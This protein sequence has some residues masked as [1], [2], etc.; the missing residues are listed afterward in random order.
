MWLAMVLMT[1]YLLSIVGANI[2]SVHWP[3]VLLAGLTIPAGTVFAGVCLTARDLVQDALGWRG[4]TV[5]IAAG[6]GLSALLA[7]PQISV[8]SVVAFTVSECVDAVLYTRLF[9]R[10]RLRAVAASNAAGL[11]VDSV[12]FVPLAF[13]GFAA[14]PGQ[15]VG[16]AAATVLTLVAL[17]LISL[18]TQRAER[19]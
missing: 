11:V 15:I 8:A 14:V 1:G 16:K 4:V 3:P 7:S 13:G 9:R 10:G 6:A 18:A 5:G 19:P 12:L 17:H 2:A